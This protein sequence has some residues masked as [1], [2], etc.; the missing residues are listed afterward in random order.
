MNRSDQLTYHIRMMTN[1]H[2]MA[3][4]VTLD[5]FRK[6][7]R[8]RLNVSQITD[9]AEKIKMVWVLD[10]E[11]YTPATFLDSL[12]KFHHQYF[13]ADEPKQARPIW[14]DLMLTDE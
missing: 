4:I 1:D 10:S 3:T 6:L 5:Q 14:L 12:A 2:Q 13:S 7:F 11:R 8:Q 9:L